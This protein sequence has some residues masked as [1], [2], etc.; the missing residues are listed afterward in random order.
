MTVAERIEVALIASLSASVNLAG[1]PPVAASTTL[2]DIGF[3]LEKISPPCSEN[4]AGE[5]EEGVWGNW[6]SRR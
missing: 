1:K 4:R 6:I 5:K 2:M 3:S